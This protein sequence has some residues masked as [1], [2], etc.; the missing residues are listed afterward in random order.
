MRNQIKPIIV[1]LILIF[2]V[3][4]SKNV[5]TI[6]G[7]DGSSINITRGQIDISP[8]SGGSAFTLRGAAQ[9]LAGLGEDTT[10]DARL[11]ILSAPNATP[12]TPI[13]L[14]PSNNSF[15]NKDNINFTW[16]AE[17]PNDD[18]LTSLLEVYND[19]ALTQIYYRDH[20]LES[21]NYSLTV[22]EET[23][24]YWRVL[25]NDSQLNSSFS[26]LWQVTTDYTIP[27]SF[28][29]TSPANNTDSTDTTPELSWTPTT[30]LNLDNYTIEFCANDASCSSPTIVGSSTSESFSN[31]SSDNVLEGGT[32]YWQVKAIDK[33]N[34]QNTSSLFLYTVEAS[35]TE[36]I[37][38]TTGGGGGET[39]GGSGTQ[40]YSLSIISPP[41]I[42]I[43]SNDTLEIPLVI[44]NPARLVTLRGINLNV[45]T[46]SSDVEPIL[47][48]TYIVQLR[49]KE[50]QTV[51]LKIITHTDPGTYGI[52]ITAHVTKPDFTDKVRIL[53]NLIE[54]DSAETK[55]VSKQLSFAK[56]LLDGNPECLDL[57]EY[58]NQAQVSLKE[59]K[60]DQALSLVQA[61]IDSCQKLISTKRTTVK[62]SIIEI[63]YFIKDNQTIVIV[64]LESLAF[65]IFL[66]AIYK[67]FFKKKKITT[68][69]F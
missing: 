58:L 12:Y 16:G 22:P 30:E 28:N 46:D 48:E 57:Q 45:S 55:Q 5:F 13:L 53:A 37:T 23:T 61:A 19:S 69:K 20:T 27:T 32:H 65:I 60:N 43:Y 47:A 3:M 64:I 21:A 63:P 36:T 38:T 7:N 11:G 51:S 52:T 44:T 29:L 9:N 54:K 50:Q 25:S 49:P 39:I 33:A 17:D 26:E 6:T 68:S 1:F 24:L 8:I 35:V 40:L 2:I 14:N 10:I 15:T 62:Q 67:I 4:F 34:N 66:L 59:G 42:T 18:I 31:W 56:D 41:D